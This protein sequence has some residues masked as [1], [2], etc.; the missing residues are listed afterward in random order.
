MRI[1]VGQLKKLIREEAQTPPEILEAAEGANWV[2]GELDLQDMSPESIR[3]LVNRMENP[4]FANALQSGLKI[5][6]FRHV[7]AGTNGADLGQMHG[8]SV[9]GPHP[10]R[11]K[12]WKKKSWVNC[13][14]GTDEEELL[15]GWDWKYFAQVLPERMRD[16]AGGSDFVISEVEPDNHYGYGNMGIKVVNPEDYAEAFQFVDDQRNPN[17]RRR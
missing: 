2:I 6:I 3:P 7:S 9:D 14:E 11:Q 8:L 1:T 12:N 16:E 5:P 17:R 13:P 15:S 10:C 4:S